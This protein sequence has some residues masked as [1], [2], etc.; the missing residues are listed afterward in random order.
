MPV[1]RKATEDVGINYSCK[2]ALFQFCYGFI[3]FYKLSNCTYCISRM[4]WLTNAMLLSKLSH[5][6]IIT[7]LLE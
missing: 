4:D 6:L 7:L 2:L 3:H 1:K 5:W